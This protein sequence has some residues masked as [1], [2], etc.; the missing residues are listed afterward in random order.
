MGLRSGSLQHF[1]FDATDWLFLFV[2]S[3]SP[4]CRDKLASKA[5][6]EAKSKPALSERDVSE[7]KERLAIQVRGVCFVLQ[8]WLDCT[9]VCILCTQ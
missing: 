5:K 6:M 1:V 3:S 4:A 7:I 9:Y 8:C 2:V